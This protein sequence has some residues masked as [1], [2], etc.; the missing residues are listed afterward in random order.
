MIIEQH[1]TDMVDVTDLPEGISRLTFA[2]EAT[3]RAPLS[4]YASTEQVQQVLA[5]NPAEPVTSLADTRTV[6]QYLPL[7]PACTESFLTEIPIEC[8]YYDGWRSRGNMPKPLAEADADVPVTPE[9]LFSWDPNDMK[10]YSFVTG[11]PTSIAMTAGGHL[12][13]AEYYDL[14][15]LAALLKD[16]PWVKAVAFDGGRPDYYDHVSASLSVI[17]TLPQDVY[18]AALA[19]AAMAPYHCS[20]DYL[21]FQQ[22]CRTEPLDGPL[23]PDP[24]G[25]ASAVR[26]TKYKAPQEEWDRGETFPALESLPHPR[27]LLA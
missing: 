26:T 1:L 11:K 15:A 6:R 3:K 4:F 17:L 23:G 27:D 21:L 5:A 19:T 10:V 7:N 16:H 20:I 13:S 9:T 14:D 8:F 22:P 24:L 12:A 2:F 25:I 18:D